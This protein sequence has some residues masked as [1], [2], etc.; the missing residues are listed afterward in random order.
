[1]YFTKELTIGTITL[2]SNVLMAPLA[3]YTC[4]PF[5]MMC[6][7]L[8][9]GLCFMEM[10]SSNSLSYKDRATQK[11]IFTTPYEKVKAIQLFGSNP[12]VVETLA[13]SEQLADF[14]IIDLNMG[15]PV[16]QIVKS[17]SGS[18]LLGDL[19]RASQLIRACKKSGKPVTVKTRVGLNEQNLIAAEMAKM[20]EDS[21]ADMITIHGRSRNMMY[22]GVPHYDQI[23]QAKS[24]VS[25]PV[26]ANGGL[27]SVEDVERM[28]NL[29]GADGVMIGRYALE[30]PFIF[31]ELTNKKTTKNKYQLLQEQIALCSIHYDETYTLSYIKKIAGFMMRGING[32]KP[33]KQDLYRCGNRNEINDV[34]ARIFK[35]N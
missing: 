33:L 20:C 13:C 31:S 16:P 11:I 28:M 35:E 14:D 23:E 32:V 26:I 9:A 30:N 10:V 17:G 5:R 29:T 2:P 19:R 7:E 6:T 22:S 12:R 34:L 1:M 3:S 8:G 4:Y 24:V 15:C 25:I 27:N 18:A 21:G